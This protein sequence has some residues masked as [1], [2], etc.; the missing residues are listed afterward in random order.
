MKLSRHI[1]RVALAGLISLAT[2]GTASADDK[3]TNTILGAGLGA[4]AGAVLSEGDV[5]MTLGGAAAGGV[6][7]NILTEDRK[8]HRHW[9]DHDR[10]YRSDRRYADS[11][12]YRGKH[13]YKKHHHK[14]HHRH[15]D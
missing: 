1:A 14:R 4:A 10:S 3:T 12:K 6:L 8:Y 5:M 15:D 13:Y 11:R 7:G 9:K 2:V